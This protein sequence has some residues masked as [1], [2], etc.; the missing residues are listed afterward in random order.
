M[1]GAGEAGSESSA[2]GV[3]DET[4]KECRSLQGRVMA[5]EMQTHVSENETG[6][7]QA[8]SKS[9]SDTEVWRADMA[10]VI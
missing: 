9:P 6:R 10:K 7:D 5:T 4:G 3:A 1:N 2:E 8:S